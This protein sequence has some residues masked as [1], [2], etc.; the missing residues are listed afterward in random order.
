MHYLL[1]QVTVGQGFE[2]VFFPLVS[3][4]E[5]KEA[6]IE[7]WLD[8]QVEGRKRNVSKAR[9]QAEARI[10]EARLTRPTSWYRERQ[11]GAFAPATPGGRMTPRRRRTGA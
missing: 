1:L 7:R 8:T 2:R 3:P 10:E 9:Q 6:A 5:T 4:D 11:L